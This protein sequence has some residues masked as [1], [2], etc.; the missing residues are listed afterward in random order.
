VAKDRETLQA[1]YR[2]AMLGRMAELRELR[3][4]VR[5][6]ESAGFDAVRKI[7]QA[8]RGSGATFGFPT[9]SAAAEI[10]ETS[11]DV[12]VLRRLEGL[13]VVLHELSPDEAKGGA[14]RHEWLAAAVGLDPAEV[15]G[16]DG[17][18]VAAWTEVERRTG[19]VASEVCDRVA[20]YLGVSVA[21]PGVRAGAAR[22]LVPE[23]LVT[24]RRVVPL[25]EDPATI[26]LAI[27]NPTDLD[28]EVEVRRLTGRAPVFAVAP[29]PVVD[30]LI[31]EVHRPAIPTHRGVRGDQGERSGDDSA[32]SPPGSHRAG[33]GG[34]VIVVDDDASMRLLLRAVLETKGW[35]VVEAVDGLD[36]LDVIRSQKGLDLVIVDLDMPRMDGLEFVWKLRDQ[37]AWATLPV[38]VVTG[39]KDEML[40]A[41][42]LEEGAD[43]YVRKPVDGRLLLA[44]VESTLRRTSARV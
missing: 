13:L 36:A 23:A 32:P 10:V 28:A 44:R 22:R 15:S 29:P 8:L 42:L 27:A 35:G 30:A 24:T 6:G 33:D 38:I 3:E 1:W 5:R 14:C 40:E 16:S 20:A 39:E 25:D 31:D 2:H 21:D 11:R 9:L 12:D 7:G 18:I 4:S 41:Q 19:L 34:R 17:T 43:D 37:K 26:T